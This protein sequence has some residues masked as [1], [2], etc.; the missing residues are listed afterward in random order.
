MYGQGAYGQGGYGGGPESW[1]GQGQSMG[2]D[3]SR[4]DFGMETARDLGRGGYGPT[5]GFSGQQGYG[6]QAFGRQGFGQQG[7]GQQGFG[8]QGFGF[9]Q[10]MQ[11]G[12]F[13]GRGPRGYRRSD[14]R[15]REDVNEE[16]TRHPEIDASDV[17]VLVEDCEVTLVGVVEDRR[18]KRLAEDIA[19]RVPGVNEVHNQLRPR[20][21]IGEKIAEMLTGRSDREGDRD[22]EAGEARSRTGRSTSTATS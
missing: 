14:D 4:R 3:Y 21:G 9:G 11:R 16:L 20:K 13:A 2:R 12:Q 7:F 19:E 5:S 10:R 6:Q 8:Q 17:E 15:I 22:R 1:G 18:D